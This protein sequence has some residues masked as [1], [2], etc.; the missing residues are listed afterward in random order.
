VRTSAVQRISVCWRFAAAVDVMSSVFQ[1]NQ[2]RPSENGRPIEWL[3]TWKN[4]SSPAPRKIARYVLSVSPML[5]VVSRTTMPLTRKARTSVSSGAI[6]P[7]AFWR[8]L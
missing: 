8:R 5:P 3:P 6:S 1:G 7:S 2:T 4:Q